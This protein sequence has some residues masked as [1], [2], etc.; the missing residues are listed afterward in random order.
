ME[1]LGDLSRIR[2]T[3]VLSQSPCRWSTSFDT[4]QSRTL[5]DSVR[6]CNVHKDRNT[7]VHALTFFSPCGTHNHAVAASN[8]HCRAAFAAS[9][10]APRITTCTDLPEVSF[11]VLAI[12]QNLRAMP[13]LVYYEGMDVNIREESMPVIA[14]FGR[15]L[16]SFPMARLHVHA[17]TG[18][19]CRKFTFNRRVP[20]HTVCLISQAEM[21]RLRGLRPSLVSVLDRDHI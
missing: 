16:L 17:H 5:P 1:R 11:E 19:S 10:L 12:H 3:S 15:L 9:K 14:S 2:W 21:L 20:T 18:A 13:N 7:R 6:T 4:C 8:R